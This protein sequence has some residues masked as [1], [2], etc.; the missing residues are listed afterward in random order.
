[1]KIKLKPWLTPGIIKSINTKNKLF[2]SCYKKNKPALVGQYKAYLKILKKVLKQA[3]QSHYYDEILSQKNNFQKQWQIINEILCR[4]KKINSSIREIIDDISGQKLKE[5]EAIC[6]SLNQFFT[7][8]GV[9]MEAKIP[10][11][12]KNFLTSMKSI[13]KSFFF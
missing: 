8:I 4:K 11:P 13:T 9:S 6:N 1:M 12:T 2:R 7:K 10:T 5:N 3:K